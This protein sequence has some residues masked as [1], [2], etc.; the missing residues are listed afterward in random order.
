M[1]S[2]RIEVI[3]AAPI[4]GPPAG[5]RR[6]GAALG[7]EDSRP[8]DPWPQARTRAPKRT[9]TGSLPSSCG[10]K[11]QRLL[12]GAEDQRQ[13][14]G[15]AMTLDVVGHEHGVGVAHDARHRGRG[16][17]RARAVLPRATARCGLIERILE[18]GA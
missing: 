16:G 5:E 3:L 1:A 2:T 15:L 13:R 14:R 17:R 4:R 7:A 18:A 10:S 9:R 8:P 11:V 6:M 12:A